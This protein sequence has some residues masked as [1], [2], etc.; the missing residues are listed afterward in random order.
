M[1]ALKVKIVDTCWNLIENM[2][3]IN[4]D[5]FFLS[6]KQMKSSIKESWKPSKEHFL[7]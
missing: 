2:F 7:L 1:M 3:V 4:L 6:I 5:E